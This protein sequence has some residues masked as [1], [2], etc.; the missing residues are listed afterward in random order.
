MHVLCIVR[1]SA[2]GSCEA[3]LEDLG[4]NPRQDI[5]L[6]INAFW[7]ASWAH[8]LQVYWHI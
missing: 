4:S 2:A 7:V 3:S 8:S 6:T 1:Q 5:R